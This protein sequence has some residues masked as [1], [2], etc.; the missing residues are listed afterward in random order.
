MKLKITPVKDLVSKKPAEL[1]AY[2][3]ELKLQHV[4][5]T[6]QI[7]LGKEKQTHQLKQLKRAIAQAHTVQSQT[8]KGKD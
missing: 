4:E 6:H 7:A 5:L 2:V 8:A 3:T 1:T